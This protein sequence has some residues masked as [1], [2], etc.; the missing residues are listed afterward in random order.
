M[1]IA[2]QIIQANYRTLQ[3]E[4]PRV[5][6]YYAVK[7]NPDASL[8][9]ALREIGSGF[10]IASSGELAQVVAQGASAQDMI[11]TNPVKAF[12][13]IERL[14]QAGIK[15]FFYDNEAEIEKIA[16]AAPG[17]QVILRLSVVNP[18]CVVD[19]GEKFGALPAQA[20]GLLDKAVQ[21]G[22]KPL[23]LSFHVGSQSAIPQP[24]V[25][26]VEL[27]KRIFNQMALRGLMLKVL[28]IGGGFP[29]SYRSSVM[30]LDMYCKPIREALSSYFPSTE[31]WAEPGRILSASAAMLVTRVMGKARRKGIT[32][33]YL[34]DGIYGSFS[35]R[36][37]DHANYEFST[38]RQGEPQPCVLAGPT[39]DSFDVIARDEFLPELAV[40]D[41]VLAQ[42]MGAYT[43][44]SASAFNGIPI[45]QV[46]T[47]TP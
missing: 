32:W 37:F 22:L 46:I 39:C 41:I 4:L 15:V 30:R 26:M 3:A 16:G 27:C 20:E 14:S 33:Y 24:Y 36:I 40:G 25:D 35:G 23:G 21:A 12:G 11:Y 28:D 5:R 19:L 8:L 1:L 13:E 10:D 31:I 29:V 47:I 6:L 38:L 45:T 7:S 42:N 34:D 43:N 2:P 17:A 9:S 18:Q 44:A